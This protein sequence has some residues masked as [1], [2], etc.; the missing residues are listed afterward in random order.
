M[1]DE[2]KDG[3]NIPGNIDVGE[4]GSAGSEDTTTAETVETDTDKKTKNGLKAKTAS[5]WGQIIAG[6]W[7]GVLTI[8]KGK[9]IINLTMEEIAISTVIMICC[10]VP[11]YLSII[12]DKVKAIRWG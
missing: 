3:I 5:L 8:L 4:T 10:F 6:I 11:V 2:T 1:S 12:M 7:T 9:G